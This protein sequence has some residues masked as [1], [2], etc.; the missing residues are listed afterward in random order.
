MAGLSAGEAPG[1]SGPLDA[2]KRAVPSDYRARLVL[3]LALQA[4]VFLVP[5]PGVLLPATV[6]AALGIRAG[7][8]WRR[9]LVRLG[10]LLGIVLLPALAGLPEALAARA[11]G[12]AAFLAAWE[13][14]LRRSLMFLLV[15]ASAEWLSR[16]SRVDEIREALESLLKPL[17]SWGGRAALA[18]ALTLGFLPWARYELARADEAA[19]LRGSDPR[20]GP[21]RH[22]AGL[23]VPLTVRLLEKS[24]LSSEALAL[25][26]A[27]P[28]GVAAA[29][30][31][32][33]LDNAADL[34]GQGGH[35][36]PA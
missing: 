20:T 7:I 25:R 35:Q 5:G 24:R 31:D 8:D 2:P 13:P 30:G 33:L 1:E 4:A 15:L 6:I 3:Y 28:D 32:E 18:A 12:T 17:G 10:A 16:T 27:D 26:N 36:N 22:L 23:G 9:W 11:Q 29:G 19:R 34:G 21:L 14:G